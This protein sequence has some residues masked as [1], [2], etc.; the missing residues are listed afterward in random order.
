MSRTVIAALAALI[1]V[2]SGT[3]G[4]FSIAGC[5][6]QASAKTVDD[7]APL[8]TA[9]AGLEWLVVSQINGFYDDI[10]DPTNRP[11]LISHA[12]SGV[13]KSTDLNGDGVSDWIVTW[14]ES[15]QFCG[16]GGCRVTIYLGK[17]DSLKRVFDRQILGELDINRVDGEVRIESV[18][19]HGNCGDQRAVCTLAWGLDRKTDQ[20]VPRPSANGDVFSSNP[21]RMPI[22]EIWD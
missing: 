4:Q 6:T 19:H 18:F 13:L 22:D 20:L 8:V 16:T 2:A 14:P 7:I 11:Q 9:S 15:A 1:F 10:D 17:T 5:G 3:G 21:D 12:P